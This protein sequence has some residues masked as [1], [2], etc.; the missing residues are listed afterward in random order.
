M[1]IKDI[2]Y[3]RVW[4]KLFDYRSKDTPKV[5]VPDCLILFAVNVVLFTL[6]NRFQAYFI[7]YSLGVAILL[8]VLF[9]LQFLSLSARRIHDIGAPRLLC[10]ISLTIIGIVFVFVFCLFNTNFCAN[11][12][13]HPKKRSRPVP[14]IVSSSVT[15]LNILLLPIYLFVYALG[16]DVVCDWFI[17]PTVWTIDKN[18]NHYEQR[19]NNTK[20]ANTMIPDLSEVEE[21]SEVRFAYQHTKESLILDFDSYSVSVFLS[22]GDNYQSAKESTDDRYE[23]LYLDREFYSFMFYEFEYKGY[24]LRIVPDRYY[25]NKNGDGFP[26]VKSFMLVGFN[27]SKKT[28][29]YMYFYDFDLDVISDKG[30]NDGASEALKQREMRNFLKTYFYWY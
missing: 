25:N 26:T 18:F 13:V 23:S 11:D 28:I 15:F 29:S 30:T 10:L 27:D 6:L 7:P 9:Y 24:Y 21:Y 17:G 19:K 16:R 22:Y 4:F 2:P 5:F 3:I 12:G 20:N 1:K 8:I 14:Y